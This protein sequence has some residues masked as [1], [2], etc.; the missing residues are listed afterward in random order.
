MADAPQVPVREALDDV[1][2]TSRTILMQR[3]D[4]LQLEA[5]RLV[6]DAATR[7]SEASMA[8]VLGTL[9]LLVG[10]VA[11]V[12]WGE[13]HFGLASSSG[14]VSA[15]YGLISMILARAAKRRRG[16]GRGTKGKS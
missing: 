11:L 10:T 4:L 14:M 7:V 6:D 1:V 15:V 16:A 5:E 3:L 9:S 2:G 8:I 12:A 13:P